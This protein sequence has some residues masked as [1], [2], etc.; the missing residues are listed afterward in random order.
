MFFQQ[1]PIKQIELFGK[2]EE[3]LRREILGQDEA[4]STVL[5]ALKNRLFL[6]GKARRP[7]ASFLFLGSTG[8]GKTM[9]CNILAKELFNDQLVD[10]DMGNFGAE[11]AANLF[12]GDE[13]TRSALATRIH[14]KAPNPAG[15]FLLLMDEVEKSTDTIR[16]ILLAL[17]DKPFFT[18]NYRLADGRNEVIDFSKVVI[19]CTTNIGA[20]A[21][22]GAGNEFKDGIGER[23]LD[24]ARKVL[25]PETIERFDSTVSYPP[26]SEDT[27]F[28]IAKKKLSDECKGVILPS[29][30]T[31]GIDMDDHVLIDDGV[32]SLIAER[33]DSPEF[34]AR[35]VERVIRDTVAAPVTN[36]LFAAHDTGLPTSR[37][38]L[39]L[40][41][42]ISR[43]IVIPIFE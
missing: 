22:A 14:E 8:T 32:Y 25:R 31:H 35:A 41:S 34:G 18:T 4:V 13:N 11:N 30:R 17:L 28:K 6:S 1:G 40:A 9:T 43:S 7:R 33:L 24:E 16:K 19:A 5:S 3:N 29:L 2:L 39:K 38:K 15:G 26:L 36:L 27:L 23:M 12:L 10:L 42:H 21:A 20:A 37:V